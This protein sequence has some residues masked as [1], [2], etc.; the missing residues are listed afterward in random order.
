MNIG[1]DL[2]TLKENSEFSRIT[3]EQIIT[4]KFA[5][6]INDKKARDKFIKGPLKLQMVLETIEQDNYNRKYGN[7]KPKKNRKLL[8]DSSSSEE[9]VAHTQPAR[10]RRMTEIGKKKLSNCNCHF[11]GKPNWSLEHICP[12]RRAQCNNCKKMGHF[13]KVCKSKTVSRIQKEPS[14]DSNTES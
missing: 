11:C 4:Y 8:S 6:A 10:K 7:K 12:A 14:T 3:P 13:A 2:S 5:A 1:K 9:H